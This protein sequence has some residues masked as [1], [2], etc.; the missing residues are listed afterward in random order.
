MKILISACLTGQ[1]VRYDGTDRKTDGLELLARYHE[2]FPVCPEVTGGMGIPREPCEIKGTA[3]E[4]VE[5]R[6]GG[7]FTVSGKDVTKEY[8]DGAYK[9]LA[10]CKEKGIENAILKENSP[11]CGS[12]NVYD[13]NFKGTKKE[14]MGI[15]S[16]VLSVNGI[17]VFN[18]NNW[19]QLLPEDCDY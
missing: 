7:V 1:K 12:I 4:I 17:S 8:L 13:G 2:I 11:S 3:E 5:N 16:Y 10:Y 9:T 6:G 14:G 15:T 18:E 19:K